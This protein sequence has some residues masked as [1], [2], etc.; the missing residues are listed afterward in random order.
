MGAALIVVTLAAASAAAAGPTPAKQRIAIESRGGAFAF[1]LLPLQAGS[2]TRD[3]GKTAWQISGT[4]VVMRAGQRVETED[5]VGRH[6][7]K[8]G[9]LV[10]RLHLNWTNAG[11]GNTAGNGTWQL[12]AGT[13]AYAGLTGGGAHAAWRSPK[14]IITWRS[15]G[16]VKAR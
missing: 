16:F 8:R 6:T 7:G 3:V 1:S 10:I 14:G 11:A 13:G 2:V 15:E 4:R 9:G 5:V 12:V